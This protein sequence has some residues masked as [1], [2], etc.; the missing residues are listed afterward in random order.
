MNIQDILQ[1]LQLVDDRAVMMWDKYPV[2][3]A[4]IVAVPFLA[5]VI[6]GWLV[7]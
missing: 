5:G 7:F 4:I 1:R 2:Y 6:I 3:T